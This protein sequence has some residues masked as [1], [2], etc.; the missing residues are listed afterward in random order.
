MLK[1]RNVV[2]QYFSKGHIAHP[3]AF[4]IPQSNCPSRAKWS[5]VNEIDVLQRRL[6]KSDGPVAALSVL[7]GWY[8]FTSWR[9]DQGNRY[10]S[11]SLQ[12]I[13]TTRT[14]KGE[15][16]GCL[17]WAKHWPRPQDSLSFFDKILLHIMCYYINICGIFSDIAKAQSIFSQECS[18]K[19][20]EYWAWYTFVT[21]ASRLYPS[22][23]YASEEM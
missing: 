5:L 15:K 10:I 9:N 6:E 3:Q 22:P 19:I 1:I 12:F 11:Y 21:G 4:G 7:W 2:E 8:S 13:R 14:T 18:S 20:Y 16:L 23:T 17:S